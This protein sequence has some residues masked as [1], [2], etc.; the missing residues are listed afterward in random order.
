MY[1]VQKSHKWVNYT[2]YVVHNRLYTHTHAYETYMHVYIQVREAVL[3]T[4]EPGVYTYRQP[5]IPTWIGSEYVVYAS[6]LTML[7]CGILPG[8]VALLL[9]W[10]VRRSNYIIIAV[11]LR[12]L[13]TI[14]M[15]IYCIMD[16]SVN[17][18]A[19]QSGTVFTFLRQK[20]YRIIYYETCMQK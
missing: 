18:S 5:N 14:H 7:F 9:A 13:A 20:P 19:L 17:L 6:V 16:Y 15:Y 11:S 3:V 4:R 8:V 10:E 2:R 1:N 12:N